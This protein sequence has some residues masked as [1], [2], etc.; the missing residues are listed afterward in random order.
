MLNALKLQNFKCFDSLHLPLSPLTVLTGFNAAGKSTA[1]QRLLLLAQA[2]RSETRALLLP[3]NGCLVRL[4]TPGEVINSGGSDVQIAAGT[5]NAEIEWAMRAEDRTAGLSMAFRQ[6]TVTDSGGVRRYDSSDTLHRLLPEGIS[7]E[8]ANVT[9]ILAEMIFLSAVRIGTADVFPSPEESTLIH[10]D[11][12]VQ[13]EFAPWWFY[14]F[15]DEEVASDRL[16]P[17]D[18]APY[19][20]RQ[21]NAW[22]DGLFPGAQANAQTIERTSLVRL[23]LRLGDIGE[24]ISPYRGFSYLD[25]TFVHSSPNWLIT[26]TAIR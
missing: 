9:K 8:A 7:S 2:L 14:Q 4:G 1:L 6:V 5:L 15:I 10:A 17:S 25:S 20:R 12:G 19:L 26:R 21:F 18:P 24:A 22:A 23:E 3:L 13:G 11:V 16:N